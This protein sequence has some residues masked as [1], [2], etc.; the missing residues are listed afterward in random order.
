MAKGIGRD[1]RR[2]AYWRRTV[3]EQRGSGL[4]VR[5]FCRRSKL[6][7]TAF[8]FWRGELQRR[9]GEQEQSQRQPRRP[10]RRSSRSEWPKRLRQPPGALRS[11]WLAV[12]EFM[13]LLRWTGRLWPTCWRSWRPSHAEGAGPGRVGSPCV[14]DAKGSVPA[15]VLR[16]GVCAQ[17]RKYMRMAGVVVPRPGTHTLRY[18]SQRLLDAGTPLKWIG[19]YLGHRNPDSTHRYLKIATEQ[20]REVAM[21]DGEDVRDSIQQY[22]TASMPMP[23]GAPGP[24][25]LIGRPGTEHM[26]PARRSNRNSST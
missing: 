24:P 5:E 19:D 25:G 16:M 15:P 11:C 13:L 12:G 14:L 4:T 26:Q 8:Y 1:K 3:R 23:K 9:Q 20:L 2:E 22:T 17:V 18:S 10:R 7:E 6:R 21:G